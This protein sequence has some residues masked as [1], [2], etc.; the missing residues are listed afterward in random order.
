[1]ELIVLFLGSFLG[2]LLILLILVLIIYMNVKRK[3]KNL[4]YGNTKEIINMIK[5]GERMD[6]YRKKSISG[7]SNILIP[8]ILAD[9]PNFNE[10]EFYNK[11][12]TSIVGILNS[13]SDNKVSKIKELAEIRSRLT[14]EIASRIKHSIKENYED[15]VFHDHSLKSYKKYEGV[16]MIEVNSSLEFFYSKTINDKVIVSKKEYKK[17]TTF[18]TTYVYIYDPDKYNISKS[19]LSVHC[20]NC[21]APLKKIDTHECAYCGSG[22]EDINLRSWYIT[23]YKEN[24]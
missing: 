18:T 23:K 10:K 14:E 3:L 9:F 4:G 7:M 24:Y 11:V 22:I 21:G 13:L 15:I 8:Q 20:P 17:Q 2:I 5:E 12:E 19:S 1:M 6:H 16:L